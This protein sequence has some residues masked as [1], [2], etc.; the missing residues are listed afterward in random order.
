MTTN[1]YNPADDGN[2]GVVQF[3]AQ[4]EE[5]NASVPQDQQMNPVQA[6]GPEPEKAEVSVDDS[7]GDYGINEDMLEEEKVENGDAD[8]P[9]NDE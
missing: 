7:E 4:S 3:M 9:D 2:Q 8:G 6:S 1:D 5:S